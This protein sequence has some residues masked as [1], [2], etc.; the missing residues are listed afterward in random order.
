MSTRPLC[1]SWKRRSSCT[2]RRLAR[3]ARPH[4]AHPLARRAPRSESPSARR[5]ARPDSGSAPTSNVTVGASRAAPSGLG[6]TGGH[7]RPQRRAARRRPRRRRGRCMPWWRSARSSRSGRNT[8]TPSIRITSRA[9]RP[10]APSRHA[11]RAPG[12]RQRRAHREPHVGDPARQRCWRRAPTWC[13]RRGRGSS[14]PS[15]SPQARLWPKA[16]SVP[17]PWMASSSSAPNVA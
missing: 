11:V 4:D 15:R 5:A 7:L 10:S 6:A 9:G 12:Q 13:S 14:P 2:M 3:P 8:S 16:L 1:G 17:S